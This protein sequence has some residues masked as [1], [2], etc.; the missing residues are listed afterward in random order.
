[1]IKPADNHNAIRVLI[2]TL[3]FP[4]LCYLRRLM[5]ARICHALVCA[6]RHLER[7]DEKRNAA[8]QMTISLLQKEWASLRLY[9]FAGSVLVDYRILTNYARRLQKEKKK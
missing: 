4:P 7:C 2:N 1:M 8:H 3:A 9:R 5:L 6:D